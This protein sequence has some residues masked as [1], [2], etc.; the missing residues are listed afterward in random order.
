MFVFLR[1]YGVTISV[2]VNVVQL[3][4][5]FRLFPSIGI[6]LK[7]PVTIILNYRLV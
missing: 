6:L 3:I 2:I 4:I 5:I 1:Y 7:P